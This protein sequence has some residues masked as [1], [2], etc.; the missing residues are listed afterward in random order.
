MNEVI[1]LFVLGLIWII[2]ASMQDL[3]SREVSNWLSFSLI[4]FALGFRFFYSFFSAGDF[5]F[6]YEGVIGLGLFFIIGNLFYYSRM[7]AGGDAKL[8]IALGAILPLS[9][10]LYENLRIFMIF[11]FIFLFVGMF[12]SLIWSFVLTMRNFKSFK[13]EFFSILMKNRKRIYFVMFI[14]L[15]LMGLGFVQNLLFY[16][17]GLFF[18][19]PYFYVYAKAV[20]EACMIKKIKSS[21][22][23]EGD[24]LYRDI[25]IGGKL[26]KAT[27]AGVNKKEINLIK[28]KYRE[29]II[30]QGIPFVP[31][32]LISFLVLIYWYFG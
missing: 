31:V 13:K 1:F 17:G 22:L 25:K 9:G 7:F 10:D 14:G 27:W 16:L 4:A 5:R 32:F 26:I 28:K 6:F 20:D 19:L 29:I 8:M 21:Q 30:R 15:V 12:Y 23:T 18:L 3:R 24:W 11:F 2:F